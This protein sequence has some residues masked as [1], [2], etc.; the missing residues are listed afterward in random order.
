MCCLYQPPLGLALL[1]RRQELPSRGLASGIYSVLQLPNSQRLHIYTDSSSIR[2]PLLGPS[3]T[4]VNPWFHSFKSLC[5]SCLRP[6]VLQ[7]D[8]YFLSPRDSCSSVTLPFCLQSP[9]CTC[10]VDM[11]TVQA[12]LQRGLPCEFFPSTQAALQ[13]P[14]T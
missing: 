10:Q 5:E 6:L 11:V 1:G 8:N 14:P 13:M 4:K 12:G 9:P 2:N 7:L 3:G